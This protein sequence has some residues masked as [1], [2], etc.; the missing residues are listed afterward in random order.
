MTSK[1]ATVRITNNSS[2]FIDLTSIGCDRKTIM[3]EHNIDRQSDSADHLSETES[4]KGK[5]VSE[6]HAVKAGVVTDQE[7]KTSTACNSDGQQGKVPASE[8]ESPVTKRQ[9]ATGAPTTT[10]G[11]GETKKV[12]VDSDKIKASVSQAIS[13][14]VI[15]LE[16][17]RKAARESRK[18][19]KSMIEELQRSVVF[20]S[21]ANSLLKQQN[22]E[23][24][25]MVLHAQ[26][27]AQKQQQQ[28]SNAAVA[29]GSNGNNVS[30]NKSLPAEETQDNTVSDKDQDENN[31]DGA[32][33]SV[34]ASTNTDKPDADA[35]NQGTNTVQTNQQ[36]N[37]QQQQPQVFT[38]G[39]TGYNG[40]TA[41]VT[42]NG[43]V[44]A[45]PVADTNVPNPTPTTI[46]GIPNPMDPNQQAVTQAMLERHGL[47]PDAARAA[48]QSLTTPNPAQMMAVASVGIAQQQAQAQAQAA[49]AQAQVAQAQAQAQ[50]AQAQVAQAQ[51]AQSQVQMTTGSIPTS[52]SK[53]TQQSVVAA[54]TSA[55]Q[56]VQAAQAQA[57]AAQ[58]QAQAQVQVA[59]AQAQAQV[60]LNMQQQ[61]IVNGQFLR[62]MI[63][64]PA[65]GTA[66]YADVFALQQQQQQQQFAAMMSTYGAQTAPFFMAAQPTA[67]G[68]PQAIFNAAATNTAVAAAS[69]AM[70]A[71]IVPGTV[72]PTAAITTAPANV[73][74]ATTPT[75]TATGEIVSPT[76]T[77]DISDPEREV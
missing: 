18:R 60:A 35:T 51:A 8:K 20:F 59:Q 40:L 16:Q 17:N 6:V 9:L 22:E 63:G 11:R 13:A 23:F 27:F 5:S 52:P 74:P 41:T 54:A 30:P 76:A 10:S 55:Q 67:F 65:A 58:A 43:T 47:T 53:E 64:A 4:K 37:Q 69:T 50:A 25:R 75:Q 42:P 3:E 57:R 72:A 38:T 56:Q 7:S 19:K 32:K 39:V 34:D 31:L 26:S 46:T 1:L 48:V 28:L 24:A 70:N 2:H 36:A 77:V 45:T 62:P 49:Q 12:K 73:A 61:A 14:R 33:K 71:A 68:F 44:A 29:N 66:T 15:R 21:R